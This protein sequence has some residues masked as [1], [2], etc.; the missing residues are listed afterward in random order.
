M[1]ENI[2]HAERVKE[3][4][5]QYLLWESTGDELHTAID[6]MQSALD[7]AVACRD[8]YMG[9]WAALSQDEGKAERV[10]AELE[11]K[12][13]ARDAEVERLTRQA[14]AY[15]LLV[16]SLEDQRT[17]MRRESGQ[18]REAVATLTSERGANA[19]LTDEVERLTKALAY[20]KEH[21]QQVSKR[22]SLLEGFLKRQGLLVAEFCR[23]AGRETKTGGWWLLWP[24]YMVDKTKPPLG[25]G[26]TETEA[27][28]AALSKEVKDDWI[29]YRGRD[30]C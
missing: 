20:Q 18:A 19:I 27:I 7:D 11:A 23:P 30:A 3:L 24:V 5:E 4:A 29:E 22:V 6:A 16:T 25:Y 8:K 28:D 15:K 10:I 9:L 21:A 17:H 13:A 2:K 1:S 26:N 14:S 12:L